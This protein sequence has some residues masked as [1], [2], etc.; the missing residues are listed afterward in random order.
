MVYKKLIKFLTLCPKQDKHTHTIYGSKDISGAAYTI[1]DGSLDDFYKLITRSIFKE[2]DQISIVEKVQPICRLVI[3]LDFKYTDKIEKRQYNNNVIKNII[4]DIFSNLNI[5]YNLSDEQKV[6]HVM[7]KSSPL[8]ASHKKY[9]SKDG[10]HLLFPYI[11][12]EKKTYRKLRELMM[13]GDYKNL[14]EDEGFIPP[15]N[16]IDEI[17]D[18]NIYKNGNWFIYGSGKPGE[19]R[20]EL[21]KIYKLSNDTLINLPIELYIDNPEEII[22]LNSVRQQNEINVEYKSYLTDKMSTGNLKKS[23]SIESISSTENNP[24]VISNAK[25]HDIDVAKRISLIL[26]QQRASNY[27]DWIEVGYCLH[28][29]SIELLPAWIAFSRKWPFYNDSS[30]CEKQW[31]WFDKNNNKNLT[32]GSLHYWAKTDNF[33]EWKNIIRESLSSLIHSSVGSSGSHA[34]VANVIY[35]YFKDCFVCANIKDNSWFY[36]NENNGGKWEETEVGHILRARLSNEIVDLYNY[37]G[38]IYKDKAKEMCD[39][40]YASKLFVYTLVFISCIFFLAI[41]ITLNMSPGILLNTLLAFIEYIFI[42]P[43]G[44]IYFT[45]YKSIKS[46]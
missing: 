45:L 12:A 1:P 15:S 9:E 7:E 44:Y 17:I 18:D 42:I 10:I 31:E 20:Y 13:D 4:N 5:L 2:G 46:Y 30:E 25:K 21:T 6:C 23:I 36:F 26:S 19:I 41:F 8:K 37:Y 43:L 40:E 28:S 29:I 24:I 34:D 39:D 27:S 22:K 16:T 14:F 38:N 32:I 11:I 33:D 3:D 35:H